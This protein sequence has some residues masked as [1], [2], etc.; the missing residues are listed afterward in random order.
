MR[1]TLEQ[2]RVM[3]GL[4]ITYYRRARNLTQSQLAERTNISSNYLSQIERGFKNISFV[5][6]TQISEALGV[7]EV[8]L[9]D[10]SR[11]QPA[12]GKLAQNDPPFCDERRPAGQYP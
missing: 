5:T 6:L 8:D 3:L 2:K 12:S 9:F 11:Y 7:E 1:L 4:N 10:F